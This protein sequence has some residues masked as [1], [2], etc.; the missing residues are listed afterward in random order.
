[1]DRIPLV[2][3]QGNW[4]TM[5]FYAFPIGKAFYFVKSFFA[6]LRSFRSDD[7]IFVSSFVS[8]KRGGT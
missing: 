6:K 5:D 7:R 8:P 2:P 4:L 3:Y 1:M